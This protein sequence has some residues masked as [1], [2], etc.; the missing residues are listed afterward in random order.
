MITFDELKIHF[1]GMTP[2]AKGGQKI[3]WK[4]IHRQYGDVVIKFY[5]SFDERSRREI[6][7]YQTLRLDKTPC[8]HEVGTVSYMGM[9]TVFLVEQFITG[10][11]LRDFINHKERFK[12]E[13]AVSFLEQ[14]FDFIKQLEKGRIVHRDIKPENLIITSK[15]Q[16]YFLDFGIARMLDKQSL[17]MSNALLGPRSAGYSAPEQF[18]NLKN[19]IDSRA[20]LFS[21]GVVVYECLTGTNPF[22]EN[23]TSELDILQRTATITPVTYQISGDNQHLLMGL[24]S[25]LMGKTPS[26]RPKDATQAFDWLNAIKPTLKRS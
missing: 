8:I 2:L 14:G 23:A 21:L 18:N 1:D 11:T 16:I 4:A 22:I 26:M 13:D 10:R 25:S 15:Q 9:E 5:L 6:E 19:E 7:I 20:D 12:I 3:V 24:I 17:T